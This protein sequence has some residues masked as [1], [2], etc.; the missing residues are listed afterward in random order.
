MDYE[1]LNKDS[2]QDIITNEFPIQENNLGNSDLTFDPNT[3]YQAIENFFIEDSGIEA[4]LSK[5]FF[6]ESLKS[7]SEIGSDK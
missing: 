7:D 3:Y 1:K 5:K 6:D 2:S 4:S